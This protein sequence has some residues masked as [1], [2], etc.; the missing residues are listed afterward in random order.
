VARG[1]I[2]AK[3]AL[4]TMWVGCG[5]LCCSVTLAQSFTAAVVHRAPGIP[6][7]RRSRFRLRNHLRE[8]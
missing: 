1:I 6:R 2:A 8:R 3:G 5:G 4:L 7:P